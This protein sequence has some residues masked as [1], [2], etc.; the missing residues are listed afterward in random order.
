VRKKYYRSSF[1]LGVSSSASSNT[2]IWHMGSQ[3]VSGSP[4]KS[5]QSRGNDARHVN[6]GGVLVQRKCEIRFMI[7]LHRPSCDSSVVPRKWLFDREKAESVCGNHRKMRI[8]T[9]PDSSR[10]KGSIRIHLWLT[11]EAK[12]R[13]REIGTRLHTRKYSRHIQTQPHSR[14]DKAI[15]LPRIQQ[16]DNHPRPD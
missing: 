9:T 6:R 12:G 1:S 2:L 11:C 15:V 4:S 13:I 7:L 5:A 16:A 8:K 14:K 3:G 10:G